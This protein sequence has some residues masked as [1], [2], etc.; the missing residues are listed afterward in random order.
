MHSNYDHSLFLERGIRGGVSSISARHVEVRDTSDEAK[1]KGEDDQVKLLYLDLNNLYG[2]SQVQPLPVGNYRFLTRA[3]IE[4]KD[5]STYDEN[6]DKGYILEVDLEYGAH[7]HKEH[8]SLPL[9]PEKMRISEKDLSDY[10]LRVLRELKGVTKHVS[11]KLVANLHDKKKYVVHIRN[12]VLY[13]ELGMRLKKVRKV[14]EFTQIP[15]LKDYIDYCVASRKSATSELK[16]RMF[17]L[18]SNSVSQN[19]AISV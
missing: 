19:V 3:E 14:M 11:E 15:F 17:K 7:L 13:Q 16:K 18:M 4:A 6:S 9:C 8:S 1:M 10:S 2:F 5:W 12:L